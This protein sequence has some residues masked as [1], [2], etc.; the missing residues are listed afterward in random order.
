M[1]DGI[2]GILG[3]PKGVSIKSCNRRIFGQQAVGFR[4]FNG[5]S[6]LSC[7]INPNRCY[8][9]NLHFHPLLSKQNAG[10]PRYRMETHDN[11]TSITIWEIV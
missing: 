6:R 10:P 3:I 11:V 2:G 4:G 7:S 8:L 5:E 1:E 9:I